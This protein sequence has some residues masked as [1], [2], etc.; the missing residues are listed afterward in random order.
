MMTATGNV[1]DEIWG[2]AVS[3]L[4]GFG[5]AAVGAVGLWWR[6]RTDHK[7]KQLETSGAATVAQIEADSSERINMVEVLMARVTSSKSRPA[8]SK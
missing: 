2:Q 8:M 4:G 5:V 1:V 3:A 7:V 6:S